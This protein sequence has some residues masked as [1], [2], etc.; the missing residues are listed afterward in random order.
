MEE[1]VKVSEG[2]SFKKRNI[3]KQAARMRKGIE[4]KDRT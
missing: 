2:V 4:E 3:R 1:Q